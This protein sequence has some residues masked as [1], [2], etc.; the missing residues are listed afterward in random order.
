[1]GLELEDGPMS[2]D[3]PRENGTRHVFQEQMRGLALSV[4]EAKASADHAAKMAQVVAESQGEQGRKLTAIEKRLDA[5][6]LRLGEEDERHG[7][8]MGAVAGVQ[9]TLGR[10]PTS[11]DDTGSGVLG[12]IA[13][14]SRPE[15]V[16]VDDDR[17]IPSPSSLPPPVQGLIKKVWKHSRWA[18]IA[19]AAVVGIATVLSQVA[20]L[21][22]G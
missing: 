3:K 21:F 2:D 17:S 14:P 11:P 9:R 10:W 18:A 20:K 5:I 15:I 6:D 19:I 8:V 7:Q 13:Q 22:G 4:G 12:R 1:M 16:L